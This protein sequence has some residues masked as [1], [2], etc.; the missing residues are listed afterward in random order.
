[1]DSQNAPITIIEDSAARG[2]VTYFRTAEVSP[3]FYDGALH[4]AN[5]K[6]TGRNPAS[7]K[8][9]VETLTPD[10]VR[11][12]VEGWHRHCVRPEGGIYYFVRDAADPANWTRRTAAH[13]AVK[14]ALDTLAIR[15][16]QTELCAAYGAHLD[17]ELARKRA[18]NTV[19]TT[20]QNGPFTLYTF[21]E[22]GK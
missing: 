9:T 2:R 5:W 10:I 15:A 6:G 16:S 14:S 18:E 20:T 4:I 8:S 22:K 13:R 21:T 11:V 19:V 17:K 3:K 1:M 7:A 12:T